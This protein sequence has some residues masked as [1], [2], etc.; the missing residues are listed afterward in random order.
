MSRNS[1]LSR[2]T[3]VC[4]L[5]SG[6]TFSALSVADAAGADDS[7]LLSLGSELESVWEMV[8]QTADH[9]RVMALLKQV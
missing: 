7:R 6:P 8:A 9:D 4:A 3:V 2:R 5:A 1:A